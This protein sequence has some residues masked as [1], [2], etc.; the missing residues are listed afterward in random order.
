MRSCCRELTEGAHPAANVS[1]PAPSGWTPATTYSA[2]LVVG[3]WVWLPS[4]SSVFGPNVQFP[5]LWGKIIPGTQDSILLGAPGSNGN[6]TNGQTVSLL[7]VS[8]ICT[9]TSQAY[10]VRQT[11][12]GVQSGC[13]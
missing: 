1:R 5:P 6:Y 2:P 3:G 12:H 10:V 11:D 7:G 9:Q 4:L 8:A 13:E